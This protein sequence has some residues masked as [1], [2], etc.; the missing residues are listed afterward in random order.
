[1]G[2]K[3]NAILLDCGTLKY[4]YA[5]LKI[6]GYKIVLGNT[7][8]KR[9]LAESK[10]NERRHETDT[11]LSILKK[12]LPEKRNL[13]DITVEEFEK[14]KL[15]IKDEVVRKRVEHVINENARVLKSFDALEKGDLKAFGKLLKEGND[16]ISRLYEV[17]GFELDTMVAEALKVEGVI[18][19]R[20]TGAGFGGC[21]VNIV[22]EENVDKFIQQVGE[23]YKNKTGLTPEFYVSEI[24][25][26]AR[27][28]VYN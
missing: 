21:T 18:G 20:M 28:I 14:Y 25:D 24:G 27:E 12:F 4:K 9:S 13:C 7:K 5:P 1:M 15:E 11:G 16:S 2:K 26:G 23:N 22:K 6:S 19:A 8:K 17:T 3:D 10:Y